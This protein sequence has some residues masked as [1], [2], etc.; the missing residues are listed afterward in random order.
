MAVDVMSQIKSIA[1]DMSEQVNLVKKSEI[2][3]KAEKVLAKMQN[4]LDQGNAKR[5]SILDLDILNFN[6]SLKGKSTKDKE[7]EQELNSK[8][9]KDRMKDILGIEEEMMDQ[10]YSNQNSYSNKTQDPK[11]SKSKAFYEKQLEY[12]SQHDLKMN[13]KR[14][15]KL[16]EER[17]LMKC[18]PEINEKS[19]KMAKQRLSSSVT[20]KNSNQINIQDDNTIK[21]FHE[22]AEEI[23]VEQEERKEKLRKMYEMVNR[24]KIERESP[25][26]I[27]VKSYNQERFEKWRLDKLNWKKNREDKLIKIKKDLTT[28]AE[29]EKFNFAP[30]LNEASNKMVEEKFAGGGFMKRIEHY[31][32]NKEKNKSKVINQ[33]TCQFAPSLNSSLP[34][35]VRK[36]KVESFKN[37]INKPPA[38][39]K[40]QMTNDGTIFEVNKISQKSFSSRSVPKKYN[41]EEKEISI[42]KEIPE[43]EKYDSGSNFYNLNIRDGTIWDD[44]K[45]NK[46]VVDMRYGDLMNKI[47]GVNKK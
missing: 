38:E 25:N 6:T 28:S 27:E 31:Q 32:E 44:N 10:D 40:M 33:V 26:T 22:R 30:T 42:L 19:K 39:T 29:S 18:K 43:K 36:E 3:N 17:I 1:K 2:N 9:N 20:G 5:D 37:K 23:R 15:E 14:K 12:K 16:E 34:P 8:P 24:E 21:P 35:H 46:V 47:A 7:K 45:E 11:L 4:K 13:N 41:E